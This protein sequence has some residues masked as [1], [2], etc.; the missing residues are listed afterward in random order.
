[1]WRLRARHPNQTVVTVA[2]LR[3]AIDVECGTSWQTYKAN[4]AALKRLG[5]IKSKGT[6]RVILTG[7]DLTGDY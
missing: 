3:R 6:Q 7:N 2:Q 1:M 4:K 5:W